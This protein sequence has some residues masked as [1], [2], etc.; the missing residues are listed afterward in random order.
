MSLSIE[1]IILIFARF[2]QVV[3][4]DSLP[5]SQSF[6]KQLK[7]NISDVLVTP[8]F[9]STIETLYIEFL[10]NDEHAD[11]LPKPT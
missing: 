5:A 9:L 6:E 4:G 10:E 8:M 2:L 7:Y 11:G 3:T 1:R